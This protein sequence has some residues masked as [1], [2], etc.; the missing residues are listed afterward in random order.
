MTPILPNSE[1]RNGDTY[2]VLRLT[3]RPTGYDWQFIPET[4]KT[5]TDAGSGTCH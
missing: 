1:V 4:G 5:F 2:G 3:L